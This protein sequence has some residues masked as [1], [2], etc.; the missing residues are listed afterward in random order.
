[1]ELEKNKK[2]TNR[3]SDFFCIVDSEKFLSVKNLVTC[4]TCDN[5]VCK[6]HLK[7][8]SGLNFCDLCVKND[9]RSE[10]KGNN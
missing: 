8:I 7:S 5:F 3:S 9:L 1:M 4:S 2:N 6:F 10:L